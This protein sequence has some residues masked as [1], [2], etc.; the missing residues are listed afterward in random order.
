[1]YFTVRLVLCLR[2]AVA[3]AVLVAVIYSPV[4]L[5]RW[6][7]EQMIETGKGVEQSR[8]TKRVSVCLCE[9]DTKRRREFDDLAWRYLVGWCTCVIHHVGLI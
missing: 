3:Q 7:E 9:L 1:M 6:A 4:M 5:F 8:K 2:E